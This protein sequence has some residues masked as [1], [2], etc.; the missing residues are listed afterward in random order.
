LVLHNF[1][2]ISGAGVNGTAVASQM[3]DNLSTIEFPN[4]NNKISVQL[5]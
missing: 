5:R 3:Q 4:S 2:E 1:G